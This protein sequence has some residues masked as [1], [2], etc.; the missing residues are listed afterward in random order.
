[1]SLFG[2]EGVDWEAGE[3]NLLFCC[4]A[5]LVGPVILCLAFNLLVH[6]LA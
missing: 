1:M 5:I 3:D 4:W 6:L 2:L